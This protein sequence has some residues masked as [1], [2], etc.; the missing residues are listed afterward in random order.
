M[1][2]KMII[3]ELKQVRKINEIDMECSIKLVTEDSQIMAL[4]A[5]PSDTVF[6]VDINPESSLQSHGIIKEE[7]RL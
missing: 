3:K 4:S 7:E 2:A 6:E 5:Y 1:K